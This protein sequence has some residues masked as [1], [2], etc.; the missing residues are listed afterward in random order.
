MERGFRSGTLIIEIGAG[1]VA[2]TEYTVKVFALNNGG[3]GA[4]SE[5]IYKGRAEAGPR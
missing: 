3:D 4:A 5:R 1:L 2:G